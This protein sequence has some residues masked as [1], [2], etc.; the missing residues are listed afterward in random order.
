M[1]GELEIAS[2]S[3]TRSH[4]ASALWHVTVPGPG[5]RGSEAPSRSLSHGHHDDCRVRVYVCVCVTVC[6]LVRIFPIEKKTRV[7]AHLT[8]CN[9]M[10]GSR[11]GDL[12]LQVR[13]PW[14]WQHMLA[15]CACVN[16]CAG[17]RG[18]LRVSASLHAAGRWAASAGWKTARG[19]S[20]SR[21]A[22]TQ[23]ARRARAA[24]SATSRRS[25]TVAPPAHRGPTPQPQTACSRR[26]ARA[27]AGAET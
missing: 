24:A 12:D 25:G 1:I 6:V 7:R 2:L 23:S 26:A 5:L 10:G 9:G 19:G 18:R 15:R 21:H 8:F 11:Q 22:A 14:R 27:C 20:L 4:G 13:D 3:L 16:L 17:E